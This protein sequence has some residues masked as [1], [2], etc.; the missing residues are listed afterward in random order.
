MRR[1]FIEDSL[2]RKL[3]QLLYLAE[4]G[5]GGE[6][7][8]ARAKFEAICQEHAINIEE[9]FQEEKQTYTTKKSSTTR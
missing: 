3:Q 6:A 7:I 8:N 4:W 1:T 5:I 2:K 9:F